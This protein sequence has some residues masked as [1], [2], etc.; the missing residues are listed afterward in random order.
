MDEKIFREIYLKDDAIHISS[1]IAAGPL[2]LYYLCEPLSVYFGFPEVS[3]DIYT[4]LTIPNE[5]MEAILNSLNV[6]E[7]P[8]SWS[9]DESRPGAYEGEFAREN[10]GVADGL[11][12]WGAASSGP[13]LRFI[14]QGLDP[15]SDVVAADDAQ[16]PRDEDQITDE[17]DGQIAMGESAV[18]STNTRRPNVSSADNSPPR[19]FN[20]G[21]DRA[22]GAVP[23]DNSE[24][25]M[26]E[27]KKIMNL[28]DSSISQGKFAIN[29]ITRSRQT[30]LPTMVESLIRQN[31]NG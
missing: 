17:I 6:P 18:F 26:G 5:G 16:L 19:L 30:A 29:S 9:F 20:W 4:I 15:A 14:Q 27:A 3:R 7:L 23:A 11:P 22:P 10:Q 12:V 24:I 2:A 13:P 8:S 31:V 28:V 21:S 1:G 25:S